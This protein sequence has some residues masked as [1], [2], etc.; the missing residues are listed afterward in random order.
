[1]ES[2]PGRRYKFHTPFFEA[3]TDVISKKTGKFSL[4]RYYTQGRFFRLID[5]YYHTG[6]FD[7][8]MMKHGK[9]FLDHTTHQLIYCD[10]Q[11]YLQNIYDNENTI[12]FYEYGMYC[13]L[14]FL[15]RLTNFYNILRR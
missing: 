13:F 15:N 10:Y 6:K 4:N 5:S 7:F 11:K 2:I 8:T 9:I 1:M 14:Q 3:L 12:H